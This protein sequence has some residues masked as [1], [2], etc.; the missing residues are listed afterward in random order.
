MEPFKFTC[1]YCRCHSVATGSNAEEQAIY[2][3]HPDCTGKYKRLSVLQIICPNPNCNKPQVSV[4]LSYADKVGNH[5]YFN[6][7]SCFNIEEILIKRLLPTSSAKVLPDYIPVMIREDYEEACAILGLSAKASATLARRC[8]QGM[9]RNFWQVNG[10]NLY[11]EIEAIKSLIDPSVWDDI[12]AVREIGNIG[13]HMEKDIN[14]IVDIDEGEAK[15]LI[16][17]IENLIEEWYINREKRTKRS[18]GI[19]ATAQRIKV[20]KNNP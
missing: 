19:L 7:D 4:R 6:S 12:N 10:T 15:L 11:Q 8:L 9:I 2:L 13:A 17:L 18:T 14:L 1:P 16:E 20:Q 3:Q 5:H